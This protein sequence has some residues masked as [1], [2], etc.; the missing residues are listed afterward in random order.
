MPA[1]TNRQEAMLQICARADRVRLI[2]HLGCG[3]IVF[4]TI[5]G[6][7]RTPILHVHNSLSWLWACPLRGLWSTSLVEC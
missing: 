5:G 3:T 2:E 7:V 6:T 4:E 1:A